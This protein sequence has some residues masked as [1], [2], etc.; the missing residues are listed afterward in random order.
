[1]TLEYFR[2]YPVTILHPGSVTDRYHHV[3]PDWA[4]ATATTVNAWVAQRTSSEFD[5]GRVTI[6]TSLGL[7]LD[8]SAAIAPG[9]RVLVDGDTWEV[10]GRPLPART[11]QG[12]HHLEVSLRMVTG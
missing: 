10:D 2:T 12:V 6:T 3:A 11:P 4:T 9:D 5:Q 7:F 1:M 8:A